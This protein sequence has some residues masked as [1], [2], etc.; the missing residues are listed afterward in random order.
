MIIS[1]ISFEFVP[2][3]FAGGVQLF[4]RNHP[5]PT[6][7]RHQLDYEKIF[8]NNLLPTLFRSRYGTTT[9]LAQ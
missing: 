9:P 8:A 6:N 4:F 7:F 2:R 5:I 1:N 3:L